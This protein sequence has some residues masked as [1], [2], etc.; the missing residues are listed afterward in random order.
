[1][2]R[3]DE[4]YSVTPFYGRPNMTAVLRKQG[5][6]V[7]GKRVRRLMRQIGLQAVMVRK[8]PVTSTPGHRIYP[9]LLRNLALERP[10]HVWC[11]HIL[12]VPMPRGFL[13]L[14]AIIDWFSRYVL[15]WQ[16]SN[17]LDG[18]FCLTALHQA[19][20]S[21]TPSIFNYGSRQPVHRAGLYHAPRGGWRAD[22]YGR[23]GAG[24][25]YPWGEHLY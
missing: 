18:S 2:R 3:I 7:N 19:F 6:T 17:S 22:Q 14:R 1:M 20:R 25:G 21:G 24:F 4:Q 8:R 9:Y 23:A 13:Y 11:A 10:N 12:D 15:A 5:Y 16:L